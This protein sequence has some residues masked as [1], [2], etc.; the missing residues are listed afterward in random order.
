M[1]VIKSNFGAPSGTGSSNGRITATR[2]ACGWSARRLVNAAP[3]CSR[4]A[5]TV[6]VG[7]TASTSN[8]GVARTRGDVE[9][10]HARLH[11]RERQE[12]GGMARRV[13]APVLVRPNR[14]IDDGLI[15]QGGD[16]RVLGRQRRAPTEYEQEAKNR[17]RD[18]ARMEGHC[19]LSMKKCRRAGIILH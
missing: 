1:R 17:G 8:C 10:P 19:R 11:L 2:L 6:P 13:H 9:H 7:P 15:A 12:L 16:A 14:T 3:G 4:C 5:Q 18:V